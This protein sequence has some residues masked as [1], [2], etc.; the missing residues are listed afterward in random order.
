[1][2]LLQ[3]A[4]T[5]I[6]ATLA[7]AL[8]API[9]DTQSTVDA[10]SRQGPTNNLASRADHTAAVQSRD[11]EY[12]TPMWYA[13]FSI[14]I[15]LICLVG[16]YFTLRCACCLWEIKVDREIDRRLARARAQ[17]AGGHVYHAHHAH[18]G[19]LERT[20]GFVTGGAAA[21]TTAARQ[22]PNAQRPE[23]NVQQSRFTIAN[24]FCGAVWIRT[25]RAVLFPCS[26]ISRN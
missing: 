20:G 18:H 4:L 7:R 12:H 22:E 21:T 9:I 24:M 23:R 19:D 15:I 11:V 10:L 3:I 13:L 17:N 25:L 6:V 1:M 5:F 8:P 14:G 26:R 2:Q 16:L